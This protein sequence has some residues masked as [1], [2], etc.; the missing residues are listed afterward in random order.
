MTD[1]APRE[2]TFAR[3]GQ[4]E[5]FTRTWS[6]PDP[7]HGLVIA[8][9]FGE[10]GGR[11]DEVG[12]FFAGRGYRVASFDLRGHGESDGPRAFVRR[13]DDYLGDLT[14][15]IGDGPLANDF[16]RPVLLA[17]SMGGLIALEALQRSPELASAAVITGPLLGLTLRVPLWKAALGRVASRLL[18]RLAL[19]T[20]I[21]G[22][23]N[24]THDPVK[25]TEFNDDE[26]I[27]RK[28]TARWFCEMNEALERTHAGA[29]GVQIPTLLLHGGADRTTDPE[30]T[31]RFHESMKSLNAEFRLREGKL[32]EILN[33]TDRLDL[34]EEIAE[35]LATRVGT[36]ERATP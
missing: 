3:P 28:A 13:W 26:R 29:S 10:H 8:H 34:Y 6:G 18:P 35:W 22:G 7:S 4:P 24:L 21:G 32:H 33:E 2:G 1:L 5:L 16:P 36:V 17:H 12:R 15:F 27:N 23:A 19:P 31:R 25:A 9:G 30:A 14:D 11:Y 20:G